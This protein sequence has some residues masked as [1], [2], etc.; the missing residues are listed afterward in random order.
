MCLDVK[1][2]TNNNKLIRQKII[3]NKLQRPMCLD[4]KVFRRQSTSLGRSIARGTLFGVCSGSCLG[5]TANEEDNTYN[6]TR[7]TIPLVKE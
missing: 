3:I 4:V 6:E 2:F 7:K 5:M 1:V